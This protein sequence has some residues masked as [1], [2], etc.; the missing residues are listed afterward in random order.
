MQIFSF[1]SFSGGYIFCL[2]I[3]LDLF[4]DIIDDQ[5]TRFVHEG[6]VVEVVEFDHHGAKGKDSP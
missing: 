6:V 2:F 4:A 1:A 3:G 5:V